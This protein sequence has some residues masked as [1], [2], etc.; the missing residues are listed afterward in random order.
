MKAKYSTLLNV[1]ANAIGYGPDA[2][3]GN[4]TNLA[5]RYTPSHLVFQLPPLGYF[6]GKIADSLWLV[7]IQ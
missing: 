6:N 4:Y 7:P 2:P 1:V 5:D 3:F